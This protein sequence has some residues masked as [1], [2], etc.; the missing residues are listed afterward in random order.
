MGTKH[1]ETLNLGVE[2]D[3]KNRESRLIC[4]ESWTLG[5]LDPWA[6]T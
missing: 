5:P 4:A 2:R 3:Q 1:V 6:E